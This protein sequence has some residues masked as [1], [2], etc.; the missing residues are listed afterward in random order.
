MYGTI[1]R[2]VAAKGRGVELAVH[3]LTG[4]E[5]FPGC[6]SYIVSRDETD[7]DALWVTEVWTSKASQE[8]ALVRPAIREA[9]FGA[10]PLIA[11]FEGVAR[12]AIVGGLGVAR[13]AVA[14]SA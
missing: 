12:T 2:I 11:L 8:S 9:I 7:A 6:L 4:I 10:A 3:V 14:G 5:H 13:P 1:S